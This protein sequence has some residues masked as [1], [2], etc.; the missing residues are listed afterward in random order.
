MLNASHA[1][2]P[3]LSLSLCR[4]L[5]PT[6]LPRKP[7]LPS[8]ALHVLLQNQT[9][10]RKRQTLPLVRCYIFTL[11]S[12]AKVD[13]ERLGKTQ[14]KG[15]RASKKT[16]SAVPPDDSVPSDTDSVPVKRKRSASTSDVASKKKEKL[17]K[18]KANAEAQKAK[19]KGV[20]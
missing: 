10:I 12:Q 20:S 8:D 13:G 9:R 7:C 15:R 11:S 18:K 2:V 1:R 16:S 3:A 17:E 4:L 14:S 6:L 19:S 5:T